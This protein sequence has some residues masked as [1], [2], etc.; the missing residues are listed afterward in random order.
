MFL[1]RGA[2]I[3]HVKPL[4]PFY[5]RVASWFAMVWLVLCA[6]STCFAERYVYP[7]AI[8]R[9]SGRTTAFAT[10]NS[11]FGGTVDSQ[12][13]RVEKLG[14]G[15]LHIT[16]KRGG[17]LRAMAA[18][19]EKPRRYVRGKDL[20]RK[21]KFRRLKARAGGHLTCSPNWA[22][23]A[24]LIPND[25]YYPQQ[26][27][28]GLMRLPAAWDTTVGSNSQIVVVIDTGVDYN[29]PD[30]MDNIW[31]N[32]SEVAGNGID[33]DGNGYIDDM[34]GINA[35]TNTGDPMDDNGHGT[36]VA[37]I[38]GAKGD[39]NRGIAGVSWES[40]IIGAKF[41]N[42]SG[43]GSTANAIKAISYAIALKRAGLRA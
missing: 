33:D 31:R 22:I 7:G 8:I 14:S 10:V 27:G 38:I 19:S 32:P 37:G 24:D 29:H 30:L 40:K 36:H 6:T 1:E 42:S 11:S 18:G 21:A 43:S 9:A 26:Y 16:E 23:F 25:T 41:L 28:P 35:I 2:D 15:V 13:F 39:N 34:Y 4:S 5:V 20:C 17:G 3:Y 12:D